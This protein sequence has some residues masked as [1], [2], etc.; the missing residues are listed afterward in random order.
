[1]ESKHYVLG[2]A[3]SLDRKLVVLIQKNRPEW[4]AGKINGIGGKLELNEDPDVAMAREFKEE[5][6]VS[7]NPNDWLGFGRMTFVKDVLGGVAIVHCF[8]LFSDCIYDCKTMETEVVMLLPL[9]GPGTIEYPLMENVPMLIE[10]AL[11]ESLNFC[12]ITF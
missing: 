1:M 11:N 9:D 3:F 4:Q 8:S 12:D 7:T 2:F 10:M 6:G 5:T